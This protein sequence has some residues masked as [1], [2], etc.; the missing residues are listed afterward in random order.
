MTIYFFSSI[1]IQQINDVHKGAAQ[2]TLYVSFSA[3]KYFCNIIQK[4]AENRW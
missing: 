1:Q 2:T 3:N 4:Y